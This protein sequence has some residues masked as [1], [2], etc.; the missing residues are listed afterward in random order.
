MLVYE[1]FFSRS[2][3]ARFVLRKKRD[4]TTPTTNTKKQCEHHKDS[5]KHT[6]P[7]QASTHTTH[8]TQH[9]QRSS[10]EM[11]ELVSLHHGGHLI[12]PHRAPLRGGVQSRPTPGEASPA[13]EDTTADAHGWGGAT[14]LSRKSSM[15]RTARASLRQDCH[16]IC[17]CST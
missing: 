5:M 15:L 1:L 16:L 2:Y 10:L 17:P 8:I 11:M 7:T 3:L 4:D 13:M 6:Q 14:T 12:T 9:D